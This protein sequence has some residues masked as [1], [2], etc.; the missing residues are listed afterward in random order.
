MTPIPIS[1]LVEAAGKLG[2]YELIIYATS[3]RVTD[4]LSKKGLE[5]L[6][7]RVEELW[8]ELR[9][10]K[11]LGF[12]PSLNL[13]NSINSSKKSNNYVRFK[14]CVGKHWSLGLIKVGLHLMD[15]TEDGQHELINQI[16]SEMSHRYPKRAMKVI[17]IASSGALPALITYISKVQHEEA[18]SNK[19]CAC[20][21]EEFLDN[22]ENMTIWIKSGMSKEDVDGDITAKIVKNEPEILVFAIG[23][24]AKRPASKAIAS[25]KNEQILRRNGYMMYLIPKTN[26]LGVPISVWAIYKFKE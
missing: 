8:C 1:E 25:L 18:L 17:N 7:N 14:Q 23:E 2:V 3:L 15:L 9:Y 11:E 22:W 26:R 16:K 19:L 12:T 10:K 13:A 21:F 24:N 4:K 5:Y 6:E 20:R